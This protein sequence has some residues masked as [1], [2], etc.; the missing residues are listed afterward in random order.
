MTRTKSA[1]SIQKL[2]A[3][4]AHKKTSAQVR[5]KQKRLRAGNF[6]L[7]MFGVHQHKGARRYGL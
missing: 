4:D 3:N 1:P 5:A 7:A 6:F 2:L